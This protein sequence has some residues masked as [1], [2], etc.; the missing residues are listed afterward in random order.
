VRGIHVLNAKAITAA[1]KQHPVKHRLI[2]D[3][4]GLF[5]Q[6][7]PAPDGGIYTS[8]VVRYERNGVAR[9]LGL[10]AYPK[11]TLARSRE[12]ARAVRD[13]LA[14]EIDPVAER[15]AL[16]QAA[17]FEAANTKTF[18][19]CA[20][21][22]FKRN[23][24]AWRSKDHV[25]QWRLSLKRYASPVFGRLPVR[26]VTREH[27][28]AALDPIWAEKA[29]TASRVRERIERVLDFAEVNFY[30][31]AGS[32]P[33]RRG[34]I[35][36]ALGKQPKNV[37]HFTAVPYAELPAF[38]AKLR[39]QPSVTAR[40]IEFLTLTA[41]RSAE[42]TGATWAEIDFD[43][44]I[45]TIPPQRT[46]RLREHKVPLSARAMAILGEMRQLGNDGRIFPGRTTMLQLAK[47]VAGG[48][49]ITIHGFRAS[50][51]TWAAEETEF[52]RELIERALAHS[53]GQLDLAY[54]RGA[55]VARRLQLMNDWAAFIDGRGAVEAK[56]A[57]S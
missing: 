20:D 19:Q 37:R 15:Q 45:W 25:R 47:Q 52:E 27:V 43:R 46:K 17:R 9:S 22:Y 30:R 8:W 36:A 2:R 18:D 33:A 38:I 11:V 1:L 32:N 53:L 29:V 10:G 26:D 23:E 34:A 5:L 16:R 48:A 31:P 42:V 35:V 49:D 44:R 41:A 57:R 6:I 54:Q 50:F 4:G 51:R 40:A 13:K 21:E 12:L 56:G 55:Q 28:K 14:Q 24:S 3:G 7:K 39:G